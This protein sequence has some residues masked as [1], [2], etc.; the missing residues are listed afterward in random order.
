MCTVNTVQPVFHPNSLRA[1]L[2]SLGVFG[3]S[4]E[5][6]PFLHR[7]LSLSLEQRKL[8]LSIVVAVGFSDPRPI[9][10]TWT[11]SSPAAAARCPM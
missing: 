6:L 10:L 5:N 9:N 7:R 1:A 3:K 8:S 11:L 4:L 2:S